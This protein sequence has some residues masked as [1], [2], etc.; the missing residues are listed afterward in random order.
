[1]NSE[2]NLVNFIANLQHQQWRV[3]YK[4]LK[5]MRTKIAK[6]LMTNFGTLMSLV[7]TTPLWDNASVAN[8]S[9]VWRRHNALKHEPAYEKPSELFKKF[10]SNFKAT[11]ESKHIY[12]CRYSNRGVDDVELKY[13][14]A[15]YP[16]IRTHPK[17]NKIHFL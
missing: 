17:A 10:L 8:S 1:M 11:H 12:N 7:I 14:K 6:L 3:F 16:I 2:R 5:Y 4:N 15:T 13:P 9:R